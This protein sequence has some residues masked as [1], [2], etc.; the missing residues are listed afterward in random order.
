MKRV[1]IVED[2]PVCRTSLSV[3]LSLNGFDVQ[4]AAGGREAVE[5][6][7]SAPPDLLIVDFVLG[8]ELDGVEVAEALQSAKPRMQTIV[9][10]GFVTPELEGRMAHCSTM[11]CLVK[12]VPPEDLIAAVQQATNGGS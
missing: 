10:T 11:R 9:I 1:L 7:K 8:G 3:L 5:I 4:A 2:D 12:P 6:A